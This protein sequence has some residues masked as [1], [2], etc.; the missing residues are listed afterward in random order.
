MEYGKKRKARSEEEMG[1]RREEGVTLYKEGSVR[2]RRKGD[3]SGA[4][5][6]W[7][8]GVVVSSLHAVIKDTG[9]QEL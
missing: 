4:P 5:D 6:Q 8:M 7:G 3:V 9:R 2:E 1:R